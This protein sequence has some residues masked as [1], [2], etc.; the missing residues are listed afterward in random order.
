MQGCDASVLLNATTG[1]GEAEKDA[2]PNLTLRGFDFLDRVKA[3]VEQECPGVVS[4]ADVLALAS[5][6]AV[7]VIVSALLSCSPPHTQHTRT[8]TRASATD[9]R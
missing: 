8:G 4:C 7:G 1:G 6:D 9:R 3:L 2:A 5:R